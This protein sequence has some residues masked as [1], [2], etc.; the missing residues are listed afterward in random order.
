MSGLL[1]LQSLSLACFVALALGLSVSARAQGVDAHEIYERSC[2]GCHA[3]HAGDF[4]RETLSVKDGRVV[5]QRSGRDVEVFLG[6]G[7]GG[8]SP[9]EANALIQQFRNILRTGGIFDRKC[10]ICHDRAVVLARANL[11]VCGGKLRGR[12]S[13]KDTDEFLSHHGRLEAEEIPTI[14][15]MFKGQLTTEVCR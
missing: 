12:Y 6:K 7:H 9:S 13:G 4:A 8:V 2:G 11:V 14:L 5:G 10:R 15:D 1:R 3:P